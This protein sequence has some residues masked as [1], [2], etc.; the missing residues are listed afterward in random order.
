MTSQNLLRSN[1]RSCHLLI[2]LL[3]VYSHVSDDIITAYNYVLSFLHVLYKKKDKSTPLHMF[4]DAIQGD[5]EI[6]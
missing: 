3:Y 1:D 6:G 5:F 2:E 4:F